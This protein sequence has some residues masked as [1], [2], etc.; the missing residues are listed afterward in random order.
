MPGKRRKNQ[1]KDSILKTPTRQRKP[2][3]DIAN[4]DQK[5]FLFARVIRH[6]DNISFR[7]YHREYPDEPEHITAARKLVDD[8]ETEQEEAHKEK[9]REVL[10]LARW[11][12]ERILF[13]DKYENIELIRM[14]EG[15]TLETAGA[16]LRKLEDMPLKPM[17][18]HQQENNRKPIK[19]PAWLAEW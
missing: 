14:F 13:G 1:P 18:P 16:M 8:W 5:K 9:A 17:R 19:G 4:N 2:A 3:V 6:K 15:A 12:K 7:P 10:E 11:M